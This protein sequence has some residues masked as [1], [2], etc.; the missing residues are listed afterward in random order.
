LLALPVSGHVSP[1]ETA[2]YARDNRYDV[3]VEIDGVEHKLPKVPS[4]GLVTPIRIRT[5]LG[6]RTVVTFTPDE[7]SVDGFM[8][9]RKVIFHRDG[10]TLARAY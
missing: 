8:P 7:T 3:V 2:R 10:G 4:T 9:G 1:K 6:A 5:P